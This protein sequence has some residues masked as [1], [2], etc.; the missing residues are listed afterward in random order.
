M[1]KRGRP[2]T[3]TSIFPKLQSEI[4]QKGMSLMYIADASGVEIHNLMNKIYGKYELKLSEAIAIKEAVM[5]DLPIEELFR[6][7]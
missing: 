2:R 5:S 1:S 7:M 3:R 6:T 4:N